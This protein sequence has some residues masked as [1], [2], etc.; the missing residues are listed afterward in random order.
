MLVRQRMYASLS[1]TKLILDF[2]REQNAM[3]GTS[4]TSALHNPR[5]V[6]NQA[7]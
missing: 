5:F 7:E 2:R 1:T 4:E 6:L 3:K